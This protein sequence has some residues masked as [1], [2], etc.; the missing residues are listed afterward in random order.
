MSQ[1]IPSQTASAFDRQSDD[2]QCRRTRLHLSEANR[3]LA[4]LSVADGISALPPSRRS[5]NERG[6]STAALSHRGAPYANGRRA[7]TPLTIV[8]SERFAPNLPP[9]RK[10][11]QSTAD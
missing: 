8:Q 11:R 10:E 9:T 2:P 3:Y 6:M 1:P 4:G 5:R 7:G